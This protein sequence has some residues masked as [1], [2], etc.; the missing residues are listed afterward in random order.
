MF[1]ERSEIALTDKEKLAYCMT[2]YNL[3]LFYSR[4]WKATRLDLDH[5]KKIK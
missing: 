3:W 5:L 1:S 2:D 4:H